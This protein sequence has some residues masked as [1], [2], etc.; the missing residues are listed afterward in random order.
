TLKIYKE[1]NIV[2]QV[3][4]L[5]PKFQDGVKSF[6]DS[7][8]IG[9]IRGTGLIIGTEFTDNKSPNDIFPPEWGIGTYFGAQCEKNGMLV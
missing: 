2:E 3:K 4:S 8:I 1:R 5:S 9:E 6:S 7:P